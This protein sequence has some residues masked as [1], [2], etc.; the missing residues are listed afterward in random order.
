VGENCQLGGALPLFEPNTD[1]TMQAVYTLRFTV[2]GIVGS[3]GKQSVRINMFNF[4]ARIPYSTSPSSSSV[5]Q[6]QQSESAIS[7]NFDIAGGQ[8]VV[9][10][11]A[12]V[13]G[14]NALFLAVEAKVVN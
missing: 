9:I 5:R 3:A 13:V 7:N 8:K 1:G 11:N 14:N 12:G 4:V 2:S 6:Y 10:G